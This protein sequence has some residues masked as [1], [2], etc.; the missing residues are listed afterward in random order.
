MNEI[1]FEVTEDNLETGL[2]GIPVGY[3]TTSHV[4]PHEGLFYR[5]VKVEK[6][7]RLSPEEVMHFLFEGSLDDKSKVAS[8]AA[9][10]ADL[11]EPD[12]HVLAL[13]EKFP[14]NVHPMKQ[15]SSAL[16]MLSAGKERL[17]Y[18]EQALEIIA[19]LPKIVSSIIN[20]GEG[21][22]NKR[23]Y[24]PSLGYI[25]NFVAML[26]I[27]T[28]D[29]TSLLDIMKLFH[30]LHMDHGGGNL[31]TFVG[32]AVASGLEDMYGSIASAMCA[33]EGPRHG[34]ANQDCLHFV[35]EAAA[36]VGE[37]PSPEEVEHFVRE[38]LRAGG[39]I[40]GF[41]HAVLRVEDPRATIFY[42]YAEKN[43]PDHPLAR[44]G[45]LLREAGIK[46]LK[47]NP[48]VQ[49]PYPNVDAISGVCLSL[50]GFDFPRYFTLLFG[51]SRLVGIA[52]Q[53]VYERL[54]AREGKGLPIVRPKYIY[55]P[56]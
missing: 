17:D 41:G 23:D 28:E 30:I 39:L 45:L 25:E 50:S 10:L 1:L 24:D 13:I 48:K 47:E 22:K 35:E 11:S 36:A 46:V 14:K 7:T 43:F 34:R 19:K 15:F 33:L 49:D 12:G 56:G 18:R 21:W 5:G 20:V 9:S 37:R 44:M 6:L 52:R 40:F 3:C 26:G 2:R 42:H 16:L 29:R 54:E 4:D 27:P 8:F 38:R 53:I 51:M 31:S 55:R 32:K